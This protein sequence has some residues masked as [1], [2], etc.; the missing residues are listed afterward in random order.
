VV[1]VP[2]LRPI[3]FPLER[4]DVR[5]TD[6]QIDNET[7]SPTDTPEEITP[8][9]FRVCESLAHQTSRH[10]I[11]EQLLVQAGRVLPQARLASAEHAGRRILRTIV[12]IIHEC[13]HTAILHTLIQTA[14]IVPTAL[15]RA[16][17]V[18]A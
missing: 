11:R 17:G 3:G 13:Q 8:Q 4:P 12:A 16:G 10:T 7:C 5:R 2:P 14:T 9:L 15:Q 18:Y 1:L 6:F